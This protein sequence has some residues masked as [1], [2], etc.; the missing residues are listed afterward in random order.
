MRHEVGFAAVCAGAVHQLPV[1]CFVPFPTLLLLLLGN[2]FIPFNLPQAQFG[3]DKTEKAFMERKKKKEE[4]EEEFLGK[5]HFTD[6]PIGD[7]L[8]K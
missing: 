4:E 2:N 6:L 8:Q 3:F 5:E 1:A 7:H